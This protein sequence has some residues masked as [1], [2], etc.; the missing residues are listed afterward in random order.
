MNIN[1]YNGLTNAQIALMLAVDLAETINRK[2]DGDWDEIDVLLAA[3]KFRKFLDGD[4]SEFE[5]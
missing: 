2:E 3:R 1:D 5:E 4:E